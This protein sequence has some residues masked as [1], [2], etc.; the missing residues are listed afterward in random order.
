[1]QMKRDAT[2][3]RLIRNDTEDFVKKSRLIHGNRYD[4]SKT[5]YLGCHE[6]VEIICVNHGSF[7]QEPS[8]HLRGKNCIR[9]GYEKT[10]SSTRDTR[11]EWLRKA[12]N[13]HNDTYD[14]SKVDYVGGRT[15]IIIICPKHGIFCQTPDAH[16]RG[17]GCPSCNESKMEA[18]IR[19]WL[20]SN[21]IRF[22]GQ[23]V[24]SDCRNPLTNFPLRFDFY[25]PSANL[26]IEYDGKQ[27]SMPIPIGKYKITPDDVKQTQYRDK[28]KTEYAKRRG[29]KLLRILHTQ[30]GQVSN[31]LRRTLKV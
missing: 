20:Q 25:V 6:K 3:G 27:H 24:F 19:K 13:V 1:M 9:C 21:G 11:D 12:R 4:Y 15:S 2:N 28:L 29:I 26:L 16:L 8:T 17:R 7:W 10:H 14:Y 18:K 5:K 22:V 23:K 30:N 31:L